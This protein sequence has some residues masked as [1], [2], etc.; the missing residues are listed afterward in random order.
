MFTSLLLGFFL[1]LTCEE[2]SIFIV[3]KVEMLKLRIKVLEEECV[4]IAA[5]IK[6][7]L[8]TLGCVQGLTSTTS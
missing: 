8:N 5:D 4:Q 1:E 7:M 6:M 3:K 2:A